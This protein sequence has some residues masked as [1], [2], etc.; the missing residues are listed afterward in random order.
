MFNYRLLYE[1]SI[2]ED[3]RMRRL[4]H[5]EDKRIYQLP[6]HRSARFAGRR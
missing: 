4:P 1:I 5:R 6:Q 3:R 2:A